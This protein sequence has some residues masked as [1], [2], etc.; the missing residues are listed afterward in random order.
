MLIDIGRYDR[1]KDDEGRVYNGSDGGRVRSPEGPRG[2]GVGTLSQNARGK[3]SARWDTLT[4]EAK[5]S[6]YK[7]VTIHRNDAPDDSS[8]AEH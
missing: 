4:E 6:V 5:R 7:S 2:A 1:G 8:A 3:I